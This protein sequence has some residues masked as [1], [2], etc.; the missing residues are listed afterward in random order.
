MG[1]IP[2]RALVTCSLFG[3]LL[4]LPAAAQQVKKE[5]VPGVT[6]FARLETTIACASARPPT[7]A[8]RFS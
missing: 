3:L 6:N 4:S 8:K 2:V 5:T 1:D 7:W